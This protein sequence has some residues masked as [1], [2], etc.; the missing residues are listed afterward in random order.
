MHNPTFHSSPLSG[1]T[2]PNNVKIECRPVSSNA[3]LFSFEESSIA[4]QNLVKPLRQRAPFRALENNFGLLSFA[5][6]TTIQEQIKTDA[7]RRKVLVCHDLMGNY[8]NDRFVDELSD[9][10]SDY[11]F[12]HWAGVD[13]FCYFSHNYVTIPTLQWINAAHLSGVKVI[14]E[15]Y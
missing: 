11:R 10:Y 14:G 4:W 2:I 7:Q 1:H 8:R 9:D 13:I 15:W 3:E 12:Y 5:R 6:P